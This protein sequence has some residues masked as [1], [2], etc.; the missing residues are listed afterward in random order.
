V[1]LCYLRIGRAGSLVDNHS[2]GGIVAPVDLGTGEVHAAIDGLPAREVFPLHPDHGAP[3][4]GQRIPFFG[5][6]LELA[7]RS[8]LAFPFFRF[9]GVDVAIVADGPRVLELNPSPDREGAAY[10]G[11]KS[12]SLL[13]PR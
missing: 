3:I 5:E 9:A 6:S 4:E 7:R 8:L 2:S 12:R 10:V 1:I 13:R 11:A